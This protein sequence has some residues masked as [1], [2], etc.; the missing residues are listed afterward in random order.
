MYRSEQTPVGRHRG[1][2]RRH[3]HQLRHGRRLHPAPGLLPAGLRGA[4]PSHRAGLQ[5][6]VRA[7]RT[8]PPRSAVPRPH[9]PAAR[10][11][12]PAVMAGGR[13]VP[14]RGAGLVRPGPHRRPG[15]SRIRGVR[16]GHSPG[17][18][19]WLGPEAGIPVLVVRGFGS[20]SYV[21]IVRERTARDPRPAVLLYVGD[22]D[23][24][25]SD[26]ERDWVARTDCW[27]SVERVL[28]THDQ[29]REH[30]LPP[31]EGKAGDPRWPAFARQHQLDPARPVQWEVEALDPAELRRSGARR[32]RTAHRPR[33]P[34][35]PD[36]RR[37]A[38]TRPTT[39]AHR[40]GDP[41][42]EPS[43]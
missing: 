37:R 31:A 24:S 16:E 14:T 4:D 11:S 25:G 12:R 32:R 26:I 38:P 39:D 8:G 21:Q 13:R 19:H 3:R 30:E 34:R 42:A 41:F 23:A 18:A 7:P 29:V 40:Q 27:A 15:R 2:G 28:L 22:F 35:R 43:R 36:R 20:Q 10:G 9:R 33:R 17:P 1:T 6:L 5:T